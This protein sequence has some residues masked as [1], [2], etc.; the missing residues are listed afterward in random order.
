MTSLWDKFKSAIRFVKPDTAAI[1]TMDVTPDP[2]WATQPPADAPTGR[3]TTGGDGIA[4]DG[5]IVALLAVDLPTDH[6]Y[7]TLT[8][9][10]GTTYTVTIDGTPHAA[11]ADTDAPTTLAALATATG[12]SIIDS[13]LVIVTNDPVSV[14]VSGGAGT[15]AMVEAA[16]EVDFQVWLYSDGW[17]AAHGGLFEGVA[18]SWTERIECAGYSRAYIEVIATDGRV[19]PRVGPCKE[20]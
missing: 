16:T 14:G 13:E 10:A 1:A 11:P 2:I 9:D 8:W 17:A 18:T 20:V 6:H 3:P 19:L 4:L 5:A 7:I 12:G 15:I